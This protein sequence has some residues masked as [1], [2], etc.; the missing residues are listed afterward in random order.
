MTLLSVVLIPGSVFYI[1]RILLEYQSQEA[2][3]LP[4]L[5]QME[6]EVERLNR[7]VASEASLKEEMRGRV[8][9]LR[10]LEDDLRMQMDTI[11]KG[12]RGGRGILQKAEGEGP[13]VTV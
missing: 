1:G 11:N 10:N 13:E 6:Q 4:L 7:Q 2:A 3:I 9:N 12:T 8:R 5:E